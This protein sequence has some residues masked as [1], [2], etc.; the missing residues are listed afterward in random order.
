MLEIKLII[1][2]N[3]LNKPNC[4]RIGVLKDCTYSTS[5]TLLIATELTRKLLIK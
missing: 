4:Q 5:F 1:K 2:N 3:R